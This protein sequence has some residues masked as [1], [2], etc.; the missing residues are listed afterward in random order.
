MPIEVI[1]GAKGGQ[2]LELGSKP[3]LVAFEGPTNA[4]RVRMRTEMAPEKR[5]MQDIALTTYGNVV[6]FDASMTEG[7]V[8]SYRMSLESTR[9]VER[10]GWRVTVAA[11][12]TMTSTP[13]H[14][15]VDEGIEASLNDEK[16]FARRWLNRIP[17]EGN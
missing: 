10:P 5:V 16:V 12:A 11:D 9:T 14:F 2:Q 8:N 7:D 13:T 4:R 15:V 1:H 6:T 17:R 3:A